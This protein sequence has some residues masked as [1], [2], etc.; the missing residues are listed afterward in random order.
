MPNSTAP[1]TSSN[2]AGGIGLCIWNHPAESNHT[3]A[4][5]YTLLSGGREA[6]VLQSSRTLKKEMC[7][8]VS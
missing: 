3:S 8:G 4:Q 7:N 5:N 6:R 1:D 2:D